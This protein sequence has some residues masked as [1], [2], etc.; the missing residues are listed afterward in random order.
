MANEDEKSTASK[1]KDKDKDK[2]ELP[3][4]IRHFTFITRITAVAV[5]L[6]MHLLDTV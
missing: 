6:G 5:I 1:E 3:W 4:M 2:E